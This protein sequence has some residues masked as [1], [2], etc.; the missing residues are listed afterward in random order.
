MKI[1]RLLFTVIGWAALMSGT[2]YATASGPAP[3]QTSSTGVAKPAGATP[4]DRQHVVAPAGGK[5]QRD[6][7]P[8]DEHQRSLGGSEKNHVFSGRLSGTTHTLQLSSG[9]GRSTS[10]S[11]MSPHQPGPLRP[12]STVK[13]GLIQTGIANKALGIPQRAAI[14]PPVLSLAS[15]RHRG[16]N[17]PALGGS[18]TSSR[19]NNGTVNGTAMHRKP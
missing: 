14:R 19:T 1:T 7:R 16:A 9:R 10:Q 18:A 2:S 3:Q 13:G 17:P 4:H 15:A 11:F 6:T 12:A 5:S 8:S